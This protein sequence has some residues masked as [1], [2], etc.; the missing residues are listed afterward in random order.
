MKLNIQ[1]LNFEKTQKMHNEMVEIFHSRLVE[2]SLTEDESR[3][4]NIS[5]NTNRSSFQ[6]T[7][8]I[9]I[10][11]QEA[12]LSDKMASIVQQFDGKKRLKYQNE[13][14]QNDNAEN[15]K[16]TS[17]FYAQNQTQS[18]KNDDYS[19]QEQSSQM[20][21]SLNISVQ[22]D[23]KSL[24]NQYELDQES[25]SHI[26]QE[27]NLNNSQMQL[28]ITSIH[29]SFRANGQHNRLDN[30]CEKNEFEQIEKNQIHKPVSSQ[31]KQIT[32]A[33]QDISKSI[34]L[35]GNNS[36]QLNQK[37][38]EIIQ[39]DSKLSFSMQN[40][41]QLSSKFNEQQCKKQKQTMTSQFVSKKKV[42]RKPTENEKQFNQ[43]KLKNSNFFHI[44]MKMKSYAYRIASNVESKRLAILQR[45]NFFYLRDKTINYE[46]QEKEDFEFYDYNLIQKTIRWILE[47]AKTYLV[48]KKMIKS[49]PVIPLFQ[50]QSIWKFVW[51]IF[52]MIITILFFFFLPLHFIYNIQFSSI[53]Y[54]QDLDIFLVTIT[55]LDIFINLNTVSY[56]KGNLLNSRSL[57]L[58][59]YFSKNGLLNIF[60]VIILWIIVASQRSQI[61][62]IQNYKVNVF[63][64]IVA[65]FKVLKQNSFK[66]RIYDRF[67]LRKINRGFINLMQIFFNLFIVCHLFACIWLV[68]GKLNQSE[69]SILC[70]QQSQD[71]NY[72]NDNCTYTWL[73]KL[74]GTHN[75]AFYEE[76]LRAYYFTTV[77]MIT[78]GYGDI[79]PVNSKEYLL[80]ILTML[81]ACGMFGYSLNSIG[82]IL[83]EMQINNKEYDEH[84]NAI[85]GFMHKKNISPDLQVQ[86]REY[87]QYFFIQ[88][89]QEDIKKQQKVI[90]LLPDTLQNQILLDAN[91][92]IFENS[93]LFRTNFSEQTIQKTIQ[94]IEQRE[95]IPGQKFIE[96]DAESENCIYFIEKGCVE[97]YNSNNNEEL[98]LLHKGQQFG[99]VQF[100][101]GQASQVSA[102]SVEFTKLLVIKR[103]SFLEIIQSSPLDLEKFCMIKDS[104]I[105]NKKLDMIGVFCYCCKSSSHLVT[106]CN[107]IHLQQDKYK[108]VKDYAKNN[109]QVRDKDIQRRNYSYDTLQIKQQIEENAKIFVEENIEDLCCYGWFNDLIQQE[110]QDNLVQFNQN[111]RYQSYPSLKFINQNQNIQDAQVIKTIQNIQNQF[112]NKKISYQKLKNMIEIQNLSSHPELNPSI[113]HIQQNFQNA[114]QLYN[115]ENCQSP[116]TPYNINKKVQFSIN[117]L[118]DNIQEESQ[119]DCKS[120][121]NQQCQFQQFIKQ[122]NNFHQHQINS[123]EFNNLKSPCNRQRQFCNFTDMCPSPYSANKNFQVNLNNTNCYHQQ[124]QNNGQS[125]SN[126]YPGNNCLFQCT[127]QVNYNM[128][129]VTNQLANIESQ[130]QDTYSQ[131]SKKDFNDGNNQSLK[132]INQTPSNQSTQKQQELINQRS[133]IKK[134]TLKTEYI[135]KRKNYHQISKQQSSIIFQRQTDDALI[136]QLKELV[137]TPHN[138]TA[139][140]DFQFD[141]L[142]NYSIYL[143][144]N[145]SERVLLLYSVFMRK[146]KKIL[147]M[148]KTKKSINK[149]EDTQNNLKSQIQNFSDNSKKSTQNYQNLLIQSQ[150]EKNSEFLNE[151][152]KNNNKTS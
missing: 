71:N 112:T 138:L 44:I 42:S 52:N 1:R 51:D 92:I 26:E 119:G 135:N 45:Q 85:Y 76:Y 101:T 141:T 81:I 113:A 83:S 53:F 104:I 139:H 41:S 129:E 56:R 34:Q 54:L 90:Q 39:D 23:K 140:Q 13:S 134:N 110:F 109:I 48:T 20:L 80:S 89:N 15:Q 137:Q 126:N 75:L 25:K 86:V 43:K 96:Q 79:T 57:I 107:F 27:Q 95:F 117:S 11:Q 10:Q 84:F 46:K 65:I 3:A 9:Q 98:K 94:I 93:P 133:N 121:Y 123:P 60:F 19:K 100:F 116:L 40:Q 63:L 136:K 142:K 118:Q 74:K 151:E 128:P 33:Q 14:Q 28:N 21:Y 130:N 36:K 124:Y 122:Q 72:N 68:V 38:N 106:Q 78:V 49:F 6:D 103:N 144:H 17:I 148:Y 111:I 88:S 50:P 64:F 149:N 131:Q 37:E 18:D 47:Q 12:T 125:N 8:S 22:N 70:A 145:N 16:A 24:Q 99:E 55:T 97:I 114:F 73:D 67:Y 127:Q 69:E 105:F 143:P 120:L 108:I 91:K 77:T 31:S 4:K 2:K 7:T 29:P 132:L 147:Q 5:I 66:N 30:S 146:N 102:R 35:S 152:Q 150:F 32:E 115:E 61:V 62:F 87:L 59:E 82:Q 58:L